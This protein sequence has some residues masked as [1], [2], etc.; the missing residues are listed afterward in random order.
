MNFA[1]IAQIVANSA[2]PR[3]A[4]SPGMK[5]NTIVVAVDFSA[6]AEIAVR[7]ALGVARLHGARLILLHVGSVPER[8][9]GIPATMHSTRP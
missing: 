9:V 8:P 1:V 3:V 6:E 5:L 4:I 2:G 7:Q